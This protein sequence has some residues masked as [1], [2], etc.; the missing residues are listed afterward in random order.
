MPNLKQTPTMDVLPWPQGHGFQG[1]GAW[2]D[3]VRS[4]EERKRLDNLMGLALLDEDICR[5]L[6]KDH[7]SSLYTAFGLSPDT[8]AWLRSI[9]AVTLVELA[10]AIINGPHSQY[11]EEAS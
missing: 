7:D 3:Y 9:P 10:E 5:R 11:L 1:T 2:W 4:K 6:L 8:Q